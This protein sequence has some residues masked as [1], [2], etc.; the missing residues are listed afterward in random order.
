MMARFATIC[1][2]AA[3]YA[4]A[5]LPTLE[6]LHA[7]RR[8]A[9]FDMAIKHAHEDLPRLVAIKIAIEHYHLPRDVADFTAKQRNILRHIHHAPF[10]P[11]M[12]LAPQRHAA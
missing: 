10:N 5:I 3:A 1:P 4:I 7:R 11:Q 6:R 12:L 9:G 8:V 2:H